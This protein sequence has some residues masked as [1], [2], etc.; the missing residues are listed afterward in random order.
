[1]TDKNELKTENTGL[2]LSGN[3][4]DF[5]VEK[6]SGTLLKSYFPYDQKP[7]SIAE[8]KAGTISFRLDG[9][10]FLRLTTLSAGQDHRLYIVLVSALL[11][12]LNRYTGNDD[13]I[14]GMPIYRQEIDGDFPN[15][16]LGLRNHLNYSMTVKELL[17]QVSLELYEAAE[18]QNYP[19]Q[20]LLYHL[21]LP[22]K[23]GDF[24]LFDVAIALKNIQPKEYLNHIGH[25]ITFSFLKK[26][27]VIEG[28]IDYCSSWYQPGTM[29][30]IARHYINILNSATSDLNAAISTI[31]MLT[32]AEREQ[33][34]VEL[35]NT[36]RDYPAEK[37]IDELFEEQVALRP[38]KIALTY[39][40]DP[41]TYAD[42]N[43][44]ANCL[45]AYLRF[46]GVKI[47]EPVALE[48]E[49]SH[50]VIVGVLAIL[51][52][53]GV[54][55]PINVEYPDERKKYILK[56]CFANLMV[57][58]N[59][60]CGRYDLPLQQIYLDGRGMYDYENNTCPEAAENSRRL[61]GSNDAAYIMYT[62]GSTGTPKGVIVEHRNAV[63]LVK[64]TNFIQFC[65]ND[66]ILLTGA[67]EFD[68]STFEI[69]GALLNGLTLHLVSKDTILDYGGL[70]DIIMQNRVT[71]M[72]LTASLF[73]R[74]L[75]SDI[76][77]FA[78]LKHLL[79]G[80]DVL[81]PLHINRVRQQFPALT[82][83]N[84]YGPTENTTFSTTF[85][86]N[87]DYTESIP[88]GTPIANS[89]AYILDSS[90]R[91]VPM[92]V[93]GELFV[94]GDGLSRG[95]L[96]NPELTAEK[97][98]YLSPDGGASTRLYRTGDQV[99][100]L[101]NGNIEFLGRIDSQV[102]IRGY[103]IEPEEIENI[104]L[105]NDH[106]KEAVVLD[107]TDRDGDKYLCAYIVPAAGKTIALDTVELRQAISL[108]LPDY[109]VP[110]S[111]VLLT[112][113][114]LTA[115]GKVDKKSLPDPEMGTAGAAY[116]APGNPVEEKFVEIWSEVLKI[117]KENIG[118]DADFFEMGGH[119][120]KATIVISK[121]HKVFHV[122]IP[123]AELF[124]T[125][126]IRALAKWVN[127]SN[128]LLN[129]YLALDVAEKK[130]YYPL[131]AAQK[132][133]YVLQQ[134]EL[135][136]AVYN[137]SQVMPM[138]GEA[139]LTKM[140]TIFR[141]LIERHESF[142]TS[143]VF[144][145][146]EPV[147]VIHPAVDFNIEY[148]DLTEN[149]DNNA[150][151][152]E[153]TRD[154]LISTF[155]R[156][157]DLSQSPLL[158]V[159]LVKENNNHYIFM[160]DIHHIITDGTSMVLLI[161]EFTALSAGDVLPPLTYQYK[162]YSQ[163]QN[164]KKQRDA[165]QQQENYW[166]QQFSGEI[167]VLNLPLDYKRP[168][169]QSF[170]GDIIQFELEVETATA[171]KTIVS[172]NGST[173]FMGWLALVN[174]WLARLSGQEDI[175][176]GT[177][178]A[179]RRHAD[180]EKIIGMFVNT[181]ALRNCP[182]G[183]KTFNEFLQDVKTQTLSAFENQE[184]QFEDL[185]EKV[186]IT[187]DASRNPLFDI[188]YTFYNIDA[189]RTEYDS[190]YSE[191]KSQGTSSVSAVPADIYSDNRHSAKFDL[192]ICIEESGGTFYFTLEYCS[193][194]FK[195]E[196]IA[197][198]ALY[199]KN[200]LAAVTTDSHVRLSSIDMIT[201]TEKHQLLQDFNNTAVPYSRA[202]TIQQLFEEQVFRTP[203]QT[204]V[205]FKDHQLTYIELNRR[206][207]RLSRLLRRKGVKAER[208]VPIMVERSLDMIISVVAVLKAGG[209][210]LP[211][212]PLY[213]AQRIA[214]LLL[215]C[216]CTLLLTQAHLTKQFQFPDAVE[217]VYTDDSSLI[218]EAADNP[219]PIASAENLVYVIYTSGSTGQPKGVMVQNNH[220]VNLLMAWR[221]KYHPEQ[222]VNNVLQM[223]SFSFDVFAGDL[224]KALLNGQKLVLC[225]ATVLTDLNSFYQLVRKE[226]ITSIDSTP[227]FVLP[228]MDYVF[229]N[230]L[231]ID[232]LKLLIIGSDSC[233][234]T[235]FKTLL[236]RFS[237]KMRIINCYGVTEA[238]IDTSLYEEP[239]EK[240]PL[241]G[242]V[243]IGKPHA[244]MKMIVLDKYQKLVPI[245]IPG[246][247]YIGGKSVARG[248]LHRAELTQQHFI[249]DPFVSGERLYK[250]GDLVK[251]QPD[252]NLEFLGRI[253][254]QVKIRGYR[255][256]LGEIEALLL[257]HASI[258]ETVV[259]VSESDEKY[260]CAYI[261][262]REPHM[263][264][265]SFMELKE[266]L[267]ATLPEYMVPAY[268]VSL[269]E[270]PLTPNNKIDRHAL[271]RLLTQD[272][273]CPAQY[274][275]PSNPI[276]EKLTALWSEVLCLKKEKIS[277]TANFFELG[278]HSLKATILTAKI[279]HAFAVQ[280]PL[281]EL[282]KTPTIK[283]LAAY[284]ATQSASLNYE[285]DDNLI[286]LRKGTQP[287]ITLF[288]I[289]DGSGGTESYLE[290]CK[291]LE[292]SM[293]CW[294]VQAD[295]L[296][297]PA[298]R[299]VTIEELA[300]HYM[301]KIKKVQPQGPYFI[302]GWSLGGTIAFEIVQQLE[303]TGQDVAFL[304]IID[305]TPPRRELQESTPDITLET[306]LKW[307]YD[308][309]PDETIREQVTRLTLINQLWPVILDYLADIHFEADRFRQLLPPEIGP[310]IPDFEQQGIPQLVQ[311]WNAIRSL[312]HAR[313]KY[314]PARH[315]KSP[316]HYFAAEESWLLDR[317]R[318]NTYSLQPLQFH[319][320][321]GDHF[322]IF[323]T[324][325]HV[326]PFA[327]LFSQLITAKNNN[328]TK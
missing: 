33:L 246:E 287:G 318:W 50:L 133:L 32:G 284:M 204:A 145:N 91:L 178:I 39:E 181:L 132:R 27:A 267:A 322:S 164:H 127:K 226:K 190:D 243:P 65:E 114:P 214:Y 316:V 315:I 285:K 123:L 180:L 161:N 129:Q 99:A 220:Y 140:T 1:M 49:N 101:P 103:R 293:T 67:L 262:P 270:L 304:G 73:N 95:Y 221:E 321:R 251:W 3:D 54:Y 172:N 5:W 52:A 305:S 196:T 302:A 44:E 265:H 36:R 217:I 303:Q 110:S 192:D 310:L 53:G 124:K 70:N 202:L 125:P 216:Q 311:Y 234:A 22:F 223:A 206:A 57:T 300:Q 134:M 13:I 248:Y 266:Y 233:P 10:L 245:G 166:L 177:P 288:F 34:T 29:A 19:I 93:T 64:N 90:F 156:P 20:T 4:R 307:I 207:N 111:F 283:Q 252:G 72:W 26:E 12:L 61:H 282:F 327:A 86:I 240:L 79:V 47:G 6:F 84:G 264:D 230:H 170:A 80:G 11:L 139:N 276:E 55:L 290:F 241:F 105:Q 141:Q 25:K 292:P 279:N 320:I 211:L 165:S 85:R 272:F 253:D 112:E 77:L 17:K 162:D 227:A 171:L 244:N 143:F 299:H 218:H 2:G 59:R 176:V 212:D 219:E 138:I 63:R 16:V 18:H 14:I 312:D 98:I 9:P 94:G 325:S 149:N 269:S 286:L 277:I 297:T 224:G 268:F 271:T 326:I 194:L 150:T 232:N 294:G 21:N 30:Q 314:V 189:P 228:F 179:G 298:P 313:N 167:P 152:K 151:E 160:V 106:I 24:A 83:T 308:Y 31:E 257:A 238:T 38:N 43:K 102:K 323:K 208:I 254:H 104:L 158:R 120:L 159:R 237:E 58:N 273:K 71:I 155:V 135:D 126:T 28:V 203:D 88:I 174:I 198:Y 183:D 260:I 75:D 121:L 301:V 40:G 280:F 289:H 324:A 146:E 107:K 66:S 128:S 115:N 173:L 7:I 215:D 51:K 119:S 81:S 319:E 175:I 306:E 255:I 169:I 201:E 191:K 142:R 258:K 60:E 197:R 100:Y 122:K 229:E 92:G 68:A 209:A 263:F 148:Y 82:V 130:E 163:W 210:Y 76:H 291:H 96:N 239:V 213:P 182:Q 205:V 46:L 242:N 89:C 108:Q 235:S 8:Q 109:M 278:G 222:N 48:M 157:F 296:E 328:K 186:A 74:M 137:V 15:K 199:L 69:W 42:V 117:A 317:E 23:E 295:A 188:M 309:L 154:D 131:S 195:K 41:R 185:V 35:N 261:V 87:K 144:V 247:L 147:Q 274:T 116:M 231:P 113:I 281:A 256:E 187:R 184:Y 275:A 200:I 250:T 136:S 62:S 168:A 236:T 193:K 37:T 118:I 78:N 56:D 249:A 259:L 97:F 45:A 153:T 225:P